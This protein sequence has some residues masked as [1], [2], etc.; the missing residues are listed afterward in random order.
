MWQLPWTDTEI[1][2]AER[3]NEELMKRGQG[4]LKVEFSIPI[5]WIDEFDIHTNFRLQEPFGLDGRNIA[6]ELRGEVGRYY[7]IESLTY[8]FMNQKIN[9]VAVDLQFILRQTM[10]VAHCDDIAGAEKKWSQAS[11][12]ERIYAYVGNCATNSFVSDGSPLK[13]VSSCGS[14]E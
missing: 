10:L 9:I 3:V 7:Y 13:R 4:D 2:I 1:L 12:A 8:D 14:C 6:P 11:D 5:N